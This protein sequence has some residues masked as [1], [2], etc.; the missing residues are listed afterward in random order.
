MG[1]CFVY[2][3]FG[4]CIFVCL[5][6]QQKAILSILLILDFFLSLLLHSRTSLTLRVLMILLR[7]L[8]RNIPGVSIDL[9]D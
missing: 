2:F 4:V 3:G 7:V 5:C 8:L 6:Y 1:L 9:E